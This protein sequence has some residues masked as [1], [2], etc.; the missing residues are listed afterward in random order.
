MGSAQ[1]QDDGVVDGTGPPDGCD[2]CDGAGPVVLHHSELVVTHR[3]LPRY[4]R[5]APIPQA[6][7]IADLEIAPTGDVVAV[8]V[9]GC[10]SA[11]HPA[12]QQALSQWRFQPVTREDGVPV[13]ARSR[14]AVSFRR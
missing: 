4:P 12:T 3:V 2:A 7:C 1:G 9:H 14:I 8:R 10:P 11:F 6:R 5:R 13:A